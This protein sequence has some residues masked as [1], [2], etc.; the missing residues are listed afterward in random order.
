MDV[1][2]DLIV[3]YYY[4]LV[5][6]FSACFWELNI[7]VDSLPKASQILE[8]MELEEIIDSALFGF[9]LVIQI[10]VTCNIYVYI[11]LFWMS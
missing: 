2:Q 8:D 6:L 7:I 5:H 3:K 1:K 4:S 10:K 11:S 9:F